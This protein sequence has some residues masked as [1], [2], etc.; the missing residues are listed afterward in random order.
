MK[1]Q[2]SKEEAIQRELG[3]PFEVFKE[4]RIDGLRPMQQAVVILH[5]EHYSK[6]NLDSLFRWYLEKYPNKEKVLRVHVYTDVHTLK[7][8]DRED[9]DRRYPDPSPPLALDSRLAPYDAVLYRESRGEGIGKGECTWYVYSP[10]LD[11]PNEKKTVVLRGTDPYATKSTI[12]TWEIESKA[13]KIRMSAYELKSVEPP[14]IY[15]TLYFAEPGSDSWSEILNFRQDEKLPIPRNQVRFI[16]DQVAYVFMGWIYIVTADR[17]KT[18][19]VWDAESDLP[20]WK[21]CD[22]GL[23]R[24]VYITPDGL[25]AMTLNSYPRVGETFVLHTKDYGRHWGAE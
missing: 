21:C 8:D 1:S 15:Y 24:D 3:F 7:A 11:N 25:G 19:S 4:A 22:P 20:N 2:Q 18:W 5:K 10:N 9:V 12:E 14:G 13:L 23:I 16:N 6:D 17:G